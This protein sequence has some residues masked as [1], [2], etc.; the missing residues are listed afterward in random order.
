[1]GVATWLAGSAYDRRVPVT[2]LTVESGSDQ[3]ATAD[4]PGGVGADVRRR[5]HPPMPS[6]RLVSWLVTAGIAA[7]AAT[8]RLIGLGFPKTK[9]FDEIYYATDAHH[10]LQHGVEWDDKTNSGSFIA[11]PPLGKWIIGLGEQIFGYNAIG[12]RITSVVAGV[13]AVVLVIRLGRRMFRS[14]LLG[15]VAGLLMTLDGMAF[16]SSRVGLLDIFLML[17]VLAG[18]ACAVMDREQTRRRWLAFLDDGGD[19]EHGRPRHGIPW[20]RLSGAALLGCGMAV[21][22]SALWY[23]VLFVV[24]IYVWEAHTRRTAGARHPWRDALLDEFGWLLA[25]LAIF[26]VVY[27]ASWAGWFANDHSWDR[28]WLRDHNHPEPPLIGSLYNLFQYHRD[29]LAFHT[30]LTTKHDY[31]SWP[32]QWLTL[33]RPVAYYYNGNGLCA[34]SQCSAEIL[35]LGTPVLWWAFIPTLVAVAWW[36]IAKR[37]WRGWFVLLTS[38]AGILPWVYYEFSDHRTM[39]YFYALPSEPFLV[40]AVTMAL[41]MIMGGPRARPERRLGGTLVAGGFVALVALCFLY[42]YPIYVGETITYSQWYARMWLGNK[43]I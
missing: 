37:D 29:I 18:F 26:T 19:P 40:L 17:F 8:L 7:I 41:G 9:I 25:S 6:D 16:V 36:S 22:W 30:G 42:F 14:T 20:W 43:W 21:K 24:L 15:A 5:L 31:Q 1:V 11:H 28:H 38:A 35:L 23:I 10:L 2:E 39:F 3:A 32:M 34:A 27:V 13:I 33:S 4:G 12:W